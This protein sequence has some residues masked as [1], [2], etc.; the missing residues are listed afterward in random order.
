MQAVIEAVDCPAPCTNALTVV[1]LAAERCLNPNRRAQDRFFHHAPDVAAL[2]LT[3]GFCHV[4]HRTVLL[5]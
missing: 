1:H 4:Q 2:V 5:S 3:A